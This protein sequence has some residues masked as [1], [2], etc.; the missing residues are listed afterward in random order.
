MDGRRRAPRLPLPVQLAQLASIKIR[1]FRLVATLVIL[2]VSHP[3]LGSHLVSSVQR[4]CGQVSGDLQSVRAGYAL[5]VLMESSRKTA[6]IATRV[7]WVNIR[8]RPR[9]CSAIRAPQENFME[10]AVALRAPGVH[11]GGTP[12]SP[13]WNISSAFW[14]RRK[15]TRSSS[16]FSS[17]C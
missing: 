7:R 9:S 2:D 15:A 5:Q 13:S 3:P 14:P 8:R 6:T 10:V 1:R 11:Q 12:M 16:I 4:E 17:T